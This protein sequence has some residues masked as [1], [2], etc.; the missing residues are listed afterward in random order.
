MSEN[1]IGVYE[2][3]VSKEYCEAVIAHY[4]R[5]DALNRTYTRQQ[6]E[7]VPSAMKDT[8]T[9]FLFNE[10]DTEVI[11]ADGR[12][13]SGFASAIWAADAEY[14]K[15]YGIL[16]AIAR[17]NISETIKVQ[18]TNPGEGY[19]LWHCEHCAIPYGRRVAQAILYLNDIEEGGETEFLYYHKRVTPKAGTLIYFPSSFT[20]THRGNPPLKGSKYIM[21]TWME[22]AF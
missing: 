6:T 22:F 12:L 4:D 20:H 7:N 1:F 17:Y 9:Y 19:H 5:M 15:K 21:N 8:K 3:V 13:A 18:K 10:P 11:Y 2:N 16:D 14:K